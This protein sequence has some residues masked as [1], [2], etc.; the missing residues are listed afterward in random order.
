MTDRQTYTKAPLMGV[1]KTGYEILKLI[2]KGYNDT[3]SCELTTT[4]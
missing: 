3:M 2:T 4:K 1:S